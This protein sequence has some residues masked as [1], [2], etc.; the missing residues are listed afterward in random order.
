MSER[1]IKP[2]IL[3]RQFPG[4]LDIPL[5]TPDQEVELERDLVPEDRWGPVRILPR[6]RR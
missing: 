5:L 4:P 6:H 1:E 3:R 2:H